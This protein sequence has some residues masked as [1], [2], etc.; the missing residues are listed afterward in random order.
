MY[1]INDATT[2]PAIPVCRLW[3][4][5]SAGLP[6]TKQLRLFLGT[7]GM[8]LGNAAMAQVTTVFIDFSNAKDTSV[9]FSTLKRNGS[10]CNVAN[11]NCIEFHITLNPGSDLV[12][13]DV[14]KPAPTGAS[15]YYQVNCRPA[16]SLVTPACISGLTQVVIT[17]CKSGNDA[18]D[19][20][21][22][23]SSLVQGSADLVLRQNCSGLL[24]K[25]R[26]LPMVGAQ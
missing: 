14:Q 10:A 26:F 7:L 25:R 20:I 16:T 18:P 3:Q 4:N 17:F 1:W 11:G 6:V 9:T 23:A 12:N 13:L 24:S 19:Y 15:T 22:S 2:H 21:I 5:I 8:L